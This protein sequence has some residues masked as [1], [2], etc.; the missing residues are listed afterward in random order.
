MATV[1]AS[2]CNFSLVSI[3][4]QVINA[5]EIFIEILLGRRSCLVV[6][7]MNCLDKSRFFVRKDL[8]EGRNL[9]S[10]ADNRNG[11]VAIA[12]LE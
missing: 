7:I 4:Q 5:E 6:P 1:S 9:K 12:A 3:D 8:K 2:A 11:G 10:L